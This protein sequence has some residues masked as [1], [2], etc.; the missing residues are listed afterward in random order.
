MRLICIVIY[1]RSNYAR[2][3]G[4]LGLLKKDKKKVKLIETFEKN[5]KSGYF[6]NLKNKK[7]QLC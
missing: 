4:L 6:N 7:I 2:I 3:K 5:K 1:N